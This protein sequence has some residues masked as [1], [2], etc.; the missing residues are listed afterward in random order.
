MDNLHIDKND[1]NT[2]GGIVQGT[3]LTLPLF[4]NPST[5]RLLV[6]I[7]PVA[8]AGTAIAPRNLNIDGQNGK[9][10]NGRNVAGAVTDDANEFIT[11]ITCA[12]HIDLP[13]VRIEP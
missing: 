1:R 11:P 2:G 5:G 6:E 10:G 13:C 12:M 9:Q 4:V 8:S 7:I 3:D